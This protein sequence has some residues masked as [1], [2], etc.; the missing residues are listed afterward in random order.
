MCA[1][2]NVFIQALLDFSID[3]DVTL[4][5]RVVT[6]FYTGQGEEVCGLIMIKIGDSM[7]SHGLAST[8]SAGLDAIP[9]KPRFVAARPKSLRGIYL[10]S[11]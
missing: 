6:A 10:S 8:G 7:F 4:F 5:D 2:Y 3:M 1:H 11:G 9:R